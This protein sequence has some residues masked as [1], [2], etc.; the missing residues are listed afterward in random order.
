MPRIEIDEELS[1][2]WD[3]Y[4]CDELGNIGHF[5]T[6]GFRTLPESVKNDR[7]ALAKLIEYF[8]GQPETSGFAVSPWAEEELRQSKGKLTRERYLKSFAAAAKRGLFSYDTELCSGTKIKYHQIAKP[9]SPLQVNEL[10]ADI[11]ALVS[12]TRSRLLFTSEE[13]ITEAETLTW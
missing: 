10:P 6:A 5:T 8:E 3:W 11:R 4:A 13:E 9:H 1:L 7:D 2:D 12:R